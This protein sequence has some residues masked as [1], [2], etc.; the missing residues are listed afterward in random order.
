MRRPKLSCGQCAEREAR[1]V[2]FIPECERP[3]N[4]RESCPFVE[5][6]TENLP[7]W[8]FFLDLDAFGP[9][10]AMALHPLVLTEEE[11][12]WFRIKLRALARKVQDVREELRRQD[13]QHP[14]VHP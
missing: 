13:G 14:R 6:W 3:G 1:D 9:E 12:Y 4:T 11:A 8:E 5:L 10:L 7:V 2:H